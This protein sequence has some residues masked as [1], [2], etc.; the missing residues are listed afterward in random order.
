[1]LYI[2]LSISLFLTLLLPLPLFVTITFAPLFSLCLFLISHLNFSISTF[3]HFS[4]QSLGTILF[5]ILINFLY[6][7][8]PH[9]LCFCMLSTAVIATAIVVAFAASFFLFNSFLLLLLLLLFMNKELSP[10]GE[11]PLI[12]CSHSLPHPLSQLLLCIFLRLTK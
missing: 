10:G 7:E 1:M 3:H 6:L 4:S 5:L 11:Y 9:T 8:I 2:G 12:R